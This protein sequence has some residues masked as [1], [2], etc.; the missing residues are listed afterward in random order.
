MLDA[1]VR[2]PATAIVFERDDS[3]DRGERLKRLCVKVSCDGPGD[4]GRTIHRRDNRDVVSSTDAPIATDVTF[5]RFSVKGFW[6]GGGLRREAGI[7][8]RMLATQVV[9][10]DMFPP[11]DR[12][13][14]DTDRPSIFEDFV[15]GIQIG[16]RHFVT[17]RNLLPCDPRWR[18]ILKIDGFVFTDTSQSYDTVVARA[19]PNPRLLQH[20]E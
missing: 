9:I 17:S 14:R 19:E 11:L 7:V 18:S 20:D 12:M 6:R 15:T 8:E 10:M 13:A 2:H 1:F 5:K 3:V 16:D 4:T